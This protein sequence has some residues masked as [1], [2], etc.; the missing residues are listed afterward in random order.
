MSLESPVDLVEGLLHGV[1]GHDFLEELKLGIAIDTVRE[2]CDGSI[3][4]VDTMSLKFAQK[5][6]N[7]SDLR[8]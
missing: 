5:W 8:P 3:A 6:P 4:P 2:V 1:P 7:S